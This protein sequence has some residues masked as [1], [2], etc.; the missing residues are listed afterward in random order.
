MTVVVRG[1]GYFDLR[2]LNEDS[3]RSGRGGAHNFCTICLATILGSLNSDVWSENFKRHVDFRP[4]YT[5]KF[6]IA[7]P[8]FQSI[9]F[10][11]ILISQN[12]SQ[13]GEQ[14]RH[15]KKNLTLRLTFSISNVV[16]KVPIAVS[17]IV[18]STWI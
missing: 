6:K 11:N 4:I 10:N 7:N 5:E 16:F 9:L 8:G 3:A 17:R 13:N 2:L 15:A 12:D 18:L 1:S 14:S